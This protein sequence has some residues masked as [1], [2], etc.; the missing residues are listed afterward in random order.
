MGR[1]AL[2]QP[3]DWE[4]QSVQ[5][6]LVRV[7]RDVTEVGKSQIS[8]DHPDQFAFRGV[9]DVVNAVGPVL[10]KHGVLLLPQ[11]LNL[12]ARDVRTNDG[13]MSREV[14][15]TVR[16]RFIGP[17]GDEL[18]VDVPGEA[19]D[20]GDKA[21]GKAMSVAWRTALI[22]ALAIPTGDPD[23]DLAALR[24]Q[25]QDAAAEGAGQ[26]VRTSP[27]AASEQAQDRRYRQWEGIL[28]RGEELGWSRAEVAADFARWSGGLA[29]DGPIET[30]TQAMLTSYRHTMGTQNSHWSPPGAVAYSAED[31]GT[32]ERPTGNEVAG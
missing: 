30:T 10:R 4:T 1:R 5:R 20:W 25:Q 22:Q 24:R 12:S 21:T 26:V 23:P 2:A 17:M 13:G 29:I 28:A 18:P 8:I 6:A 3:S 32:P 11:L 27:P 9:D 31:A 7:M 19:V 15:V 14:T 16:Y